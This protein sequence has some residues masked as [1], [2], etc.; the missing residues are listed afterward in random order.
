MSLSLAYEN[1]FVISLTFTSPNPKVCNL[2]PQ[3]CEEQLIISL[4]SGEGKIREV[5]KGFSYAEEDSQDTRG[6]LL[7]SQGWFLSHRVEE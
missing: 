4:R 2:L 3:D 5:P 1:L 7:S 6:L